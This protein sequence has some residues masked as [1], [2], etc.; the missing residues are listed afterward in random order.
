MSRRQFSN[1]A[2]REG[3][4]MQDETYLKE[5][6][7]KKKEIMDAYNKTA[8]F[9]DIRYDKIQRRK[10]EYALKILDNKFKPHLFNVSLDLGCGTGLLNTYLKQKVNRIIGI[11]ISQEMLK[12]A[13]NRGY[14]NVVLGDAEALPFRHNVFDVVFSFTLLQNVAVKNKAVSEAKRVAKQGAKLIFSTLAK[15]TNIET[16]KNIFVSSKLNII[17]LNLIPDSE[18]FLCI[19]EIM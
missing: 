1:E 9:Y 5:D 2:S 3:G 17:T 8:K 10:Y 15:K 16:L 18:D 14:T 4:I 11:D 12:R 7:S 19:S 13:C 6:D